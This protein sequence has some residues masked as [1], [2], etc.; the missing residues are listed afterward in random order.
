LAVG[1]GSLFAGTDRGDI[2]VFD[3]KR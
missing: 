2:F 1:N 3:T